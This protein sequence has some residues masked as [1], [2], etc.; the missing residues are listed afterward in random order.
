VT[1]EI[2]SN[3][4]SSSVE[5]EVIRVDFA[6]KYDAL[7]ELLK[8]PEMARV[9]VFNETKHGAE[10]LAKNLQ[11]DGFAADAIHGGRSQP[12]RQRALNAFKSGAVK[13]LV[14]TDVAA[15]G[16]DVKNV[17]HVVNYTLPHTREDYVHRVGRTGRGGETGKAY[18]FV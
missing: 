13:V 7:C 8:R 3:R 12:Q 9:L 18:S 11:K 1:I 5:Q 6:K 10:K 17:S 15:R 14:A 4:S 2:A 16:I